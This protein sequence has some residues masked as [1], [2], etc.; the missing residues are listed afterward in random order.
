[1]TRLG[2]A[3]FAVVLATLLV[4]IGITATWLSLRVDST[5]AYVDTVAPLADDPELRDALADEVSDAAVTRLQELVPAPLLPASLGPVVRASAQEVVENDGFPEF[6][7]G[8]NAEAHRE[9]LAIVH[10]RSGVV[11][12]GWVFIDVGP[13]L[14]DVLADFVAG[15]SGFNVE[16]PSQTL[17]VPVFPESKLEEARG[18]YLALDFLAVW[19]PL[20]WVALAA[21]AVLVAPGWRGRLRTGAACALG[22]AVGGVLVM[23]LTGAATEVALEQVDA[24]QRDLARLV[25]EVVVGSLDNSAA[26]AAIAGLV[27]GG[28]LLVC[29]F[30]PQPGRSRE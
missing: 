12:D 24:A 25:V 6:W 15:L 18:A 29:S 7:R 22:V 11:H 1:M 26:A 14:D 16:L 2:L 21:F 20:G 17:M 5:E 3:A 4:P 10:E 19:V 23:V 30:L 28:G 27:V 8:A 9:F 13:L